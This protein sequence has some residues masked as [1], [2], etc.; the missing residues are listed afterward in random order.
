MGK[1]YKPVT[2]LLCISDLDGIFSDICDLGEE[3]QEVFDSTPE[4]LQQTDRCVAFEA[5]AEALSHIGSTTIPPGVEDL[6][7]TYEEM[8]PRRRRSATSRSVRASNMSSALQAANECLIDWLVED[9]N[10]EH[11]DRDDVEQLSTVIEEAVDALEG[12]EFPGMF[13]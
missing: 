6:T 12:C 11:E 7:F 13:G 8:I 5:S 2:T 3:C 10:G 4:S 1:N 9:D